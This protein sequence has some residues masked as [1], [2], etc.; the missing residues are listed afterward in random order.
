MIL[1]SFLTI[2]NLRKKEKKVNLKGKKTKQKEEETEKEKQKHNTKQKK[3]YISAQLGRPVRI[4]DY[5]TLIA[6]NRI[7]PPACT[8]K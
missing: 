2:L 5:V 6:I 8:R 7:F 1:C 4:Y 3:E